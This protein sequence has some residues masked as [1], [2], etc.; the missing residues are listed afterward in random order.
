VISSLIY[1][2]HRQAGD[3]LVRLGTKLA[4]QATTVA[5]SPAVASQNPVGEDGSASN[6]NLDGQV[7]Q[8]VPQP[9]F[10]DPGKIAQEIPAG[11]SATQVRETPVRPEKPA[12][13]GAELVVQ[14]AALKEEVEARKLTDR[15]R[16]EN[17]QAFVGTLPADSFYRVMLGP[18][19]DESSARV[20]LGK[21]KK[22]GFDS[23]IRRESFAELSDLN[24]QRQP[25]RNRQ[26]DQQVSSNSLPLTN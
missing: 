23:F 18:Y 22:A 17:F 21:L 24:E 8:A 9:V 6:S 12:A 14:V 15:L 26:P 19:A 1:V 4:G 25:D 10:A 20:V 2:R 11:M 7:A 13:Q 5:P 16:H 3:L